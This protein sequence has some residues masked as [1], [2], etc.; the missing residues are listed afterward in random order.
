MTPE[1]WERIKQVLEEAIERPTAER[2][3][4][5][6]AVAQDDAALAVEVRSL[7][8]AHAQAGSFI[9]TPAL[10]R[11]GMATAFDRLQDVPT[12]AGRRVGP[13]QVVR[14]LGHGGMGVVYLAVR[15]DD[16]YR[17]QVAIK[18]IR[19]AFDPPSIQ[20]R[21]R[22]ERQILADLDHPNIARLI[23]G[24]STDDGA[25]YFVMEYIDGLPIDRYS[26]VNGLTID[27][28]LA[29]FLQVCAAV[30]Y[31]H[32]HLVV[33]RDLKAGNVLVSAGGVPK[34]LDFGIAKLVDADTGAPEERTMT[35][36]RA[37]TFESA[38]PEQ[39]RGDAVTTRTDVY[40]LGVM[41]HRLLTGGGPYSATTTT[42][43]LAR[44]ICDDDARKPSDVAAN[45]ANARRLEGDLDTIVLKALQKDPSRRYATVEQ[46]AQ[47]ITRHLEGRP[48]LA[49][50]DTIR[51]RATKFVSRH[52]AGVAASALVVLSL[53]GGVVATAWQAHVAGVQRGRAER[54]FNDVRRLANSFLFEFHDAIEDL[55]GS[56]KA[57]ELVVRRAGE[58]L[59]SL[60]AESSNDPSLERELA[61]AYDKVG[62]VQGLPSFA[63]LGDTAGAVRSHERAL[64]LRQSLAAAS[65]SDAGLQ[66][67]L[68]TTHSHL[69][70]LF[71][72]TRDFPAALDHARKA[73][74]L[75]EALLARNPGGFLER[76]SAAAG[77]HHI[78]SIMIAT[79]DWKG[80]LE[81][82]QRETGEFEALLAQNPSNGAAQRNAAIAYRRLG[83]LLERNGDSTAG[84][85]HYRK[86][87][88]LDE[89]RVRA[90]GNDGRA[91]LDLSYDYASIGYTLS[92]LGDI[93]A[94]LS[95]Y[96]QALAEREWAARADPNDVNARDTVI[97]AHL[98]I[99]QVFRKASRPLEALP[100]LH[101]AREIAAARYTSD[102]ANVV[103]GQ[104]LANV[105]STLAETY[106]GLAS[107]AKYSGAGIGQCREARTW[108]QK[109]V[110]IWHAQRAKGPL[111]ADA[112][113]GL[114]SLVALVARCDAALAGPPAPPRR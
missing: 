5:L 73:L 25:P 86:A 6:A 95:S 56:T 33:H 78:A 22:H 18:V 52:R 97:R 20:Q 64:A 88:V 42:H 8:A 113:S 32:Q 4:F 3:P 57:R 72:V 30:Q 55:P 98:S 38:S 114:D 10:A 31:A 84:L 110:E 28:R 90:N 53:V 71:E 1:R 61:A 11:G 107:A 112:A 103:A 81:N 83:A 26:D 69:G 99:G 63:N 68:V 60:A 15:A 70:A 80:A 21:F 106:A 48:V 89:G 91:R 50:P 44:A 34:L 19:S 16:E 54:R 104:R 108:G 45:A 27:A 17:K 41:L 93:E 2:G 94:S 29:L 12:W 111:S 65:P 9:E 67:D 37:M 23:D 35:V 46:F 59:D 62:D 109:S 76:S 75:R 58:Y 47:D 82:V 43:D 92:T 105:Y 36:M 102:P 14:E 49:Q 40:A 101:K 100:H 79:G 13:Y 7:L 96:R 87:A 24:G 74:A 66:G 85:A 39:V 77:Y 51:Y